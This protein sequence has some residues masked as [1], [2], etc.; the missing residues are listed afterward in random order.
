MRTFIAIELN[1]QTKQK[2]KELEDKIKDLIIGQIK[3]VEPEN[4]HLTLK[5]LGE[6]KE[7]KINSFA[8]EINKIVANFSPFEL[9][10]GNIGFFP[11]VKMP[12]VLWLGVTE[13][14]GQLFQLKQDL[15]KNLKK[16]GSLEEKREFSPHLTLARIKN[17]ISLSQ[18]FENLKEY[19][20]GKERVEGLSFIQSK[21]TRQGPV[22]TLLKKFNFN[23]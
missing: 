13:K 19:K 2:I 12:R 6:I 20:I 18:Q 11:S 3:M 21:L 1:E 16:L 14:S 8:E 10:I 9:E 7:E 4:L 17:K 15:E 22:Y 5:F 23:I